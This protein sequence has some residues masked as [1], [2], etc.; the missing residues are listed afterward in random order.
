MYKS[1]LK[2]L[3]RDELITLGTK[4]LTSNTLIFEGRNYA[5]ARVTK[6]RRSYEDIRVACNSNNM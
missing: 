6:I 5:K 4:E 3:D 2:R 1:V